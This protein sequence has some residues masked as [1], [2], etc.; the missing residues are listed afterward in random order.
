MS[1]ARR[2]RAT[3]KVTDFDAVRK[4]RDRVLGE[5]P[6]VKIGGKNYKLCPTLPLAVTDYFAE[7][8][9]KDKEGNTTVLLGDMQAILAKLFGADQWA[10]IRE[11]IDIADV[12]TLFDVVFKSYG[13]ATGESSNSGQS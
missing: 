6:P 9:S 11:V 12:P 10:E 2:P 7:N 3:T 13:E 4:K 1:N 5:I 8:S